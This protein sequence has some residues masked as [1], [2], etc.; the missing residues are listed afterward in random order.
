MAFSR[1]GRT[2]ATGSNDRTVILWDVADRSRPIRLGRLAGHTKAV[3]SVAF[4]RDGKTVAS[5][6]DDNVGDLVGC[7]RIGPTRFSLASH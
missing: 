4:S 1:D 7:T 6:G 5:G 3:E 2:L